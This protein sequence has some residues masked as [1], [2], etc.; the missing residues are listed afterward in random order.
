MNIVLPY[1]F[2]ET[3]ELKYAL[4][5]I[6]KHLT[7]Y[8]NIFLVGDRIPKWVQNVEFIYCSEESVKC[9]KNI[10][11]KLVVASNHPDVGAQFLQWQDDIYL[12]KPLTVN[13]TKYWYDGSLEGAL[14]KAFGRY[15]KIITNTALKLTG[16]ARFY[17]I[18]TPIIYKGEWLKQ[19]AHHWN[20]KDYLIKT[21]YCVSNEDNREQM[22][23]CMIDVAQSKEVIYSKIKDKLFFTTYS[24]IDDTIIEVLEELYP[25][26]SKYER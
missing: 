11:N 26:K 20:G 19:I 15:H 18:H 1:R 16:E 22:K 7:G 10:L 23:D 2:V 6:Q 3:P 5:S 24:Q 14:D 13:D 25:E 4:R 9:A 17:D 12:L 8:D 21:M